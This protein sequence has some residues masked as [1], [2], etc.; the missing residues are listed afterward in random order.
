MPYAAYL[1]EQSS[2]CIQLAVKHP[3][4]NDAGDLID[5]AL[6]Y[7]A[8]AS[9]LDVETALGRPAAEPKLW[10]LFRGSTSI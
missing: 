2:D 3:W 5:L 8:M 7:C 9:S 1:R 10:R 6:N 4:S